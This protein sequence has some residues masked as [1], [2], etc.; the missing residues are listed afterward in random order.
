MSVQVVEEGHPLLD[1]VL[2]L[3]HQM[4]GAAE[5]HAACRERRVGRLDVRDAEV[6][7]GRHGRRSFDGLALA[8]LGA[9]EQ[10]DTAAVEEG[11]VAKRVQVCKRVLCEFLKVCPRS[12]L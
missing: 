11:E 1:P 7:Q 2:V 3:V 6:E 4:G 12:L 10:P 5:F 9:Q 8:L